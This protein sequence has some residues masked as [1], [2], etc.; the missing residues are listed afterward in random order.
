MAPRLNVG[1]VIACDANA[2][3]TT[4]APSKALCQK[5]AGRCGSKL[6]LFQIRN[7][8]PS[9]GTIGPMLSKATGI[10]AIDIGIPQLAMH[11]IR[12]TI[13]SNDPAL[14]IKFF[15]GFFREFES[16]ESTIHVD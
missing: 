12:A 2:H 4:D 7:G 13:G 9:G 1:P 14:G 10:R 6:Q 5:I 16:V 15:E 11:S 8:Q 3:M